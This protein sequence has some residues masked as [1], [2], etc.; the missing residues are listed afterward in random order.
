MSPTASGFLL[1][2]LG[3]LALLVVDMIIALIEGVTLTLLKW[4]S[5]RT[6]LMV[7]YIMNIISGIV[8][9]ILLVLLQHA[10]LVWLPISF[11]IS[12]LIEG[13]IMSYFKRDAL[14]QNGIFVF[15]ANLAS[16]LLLILPAYYFGTHP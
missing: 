8:N 1:V 11:V 9:G 12:L 15:L 13:F 7:S 3:I 4:G 10:P 6:S 16:Y 2:V 5:T 14:L